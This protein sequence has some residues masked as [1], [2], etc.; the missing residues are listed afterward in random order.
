MQTEKD[1]LDYW[2]EKRDLSK[3]TRELYKGTLKQY[4]RLIV[5]QF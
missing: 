5:N 2:F 1:I 3:S 4:S